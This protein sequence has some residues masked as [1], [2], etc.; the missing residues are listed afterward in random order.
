M[1]CKPPLRLRAPTP[2]QSRA[3]VS[4]EWS[5]RVSGS[6]PGTTRDRSADKG[7]QAAA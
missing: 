7:S 2:G 1:H 4:Y 5:T 6:N 3:F